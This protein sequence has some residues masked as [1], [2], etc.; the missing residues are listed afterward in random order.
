M[1]K[2]TPIV[3]KKNIKSF[4]IASADGI[5]CK[6]WSRG[7]PNKPV[8]KRLRGTRMW[9]FAKNSPVKIPIIVLLQPI[10]MKIGPNWG[11]TGN[12]FIRPLSI[13]IPMRMNTKPCPASP[14]IMPNKSVKKKA[15]KGVG[16]IVPYRGAP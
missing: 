6:M 14:N 13:K 10:A 9:P 2:P 7:V 1:I 4:P 15:T 8:K 3:N 12:F 5:K 16:S 11:D